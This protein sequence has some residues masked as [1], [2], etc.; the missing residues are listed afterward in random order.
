MAGKVKDAL[1]STARVV[2]SSLNDKEV[3]VRL[4]V[5]LLLY[6][7][8]IAFT[9]AYGLIQNHSRNVTQELLRLPLTSKSFVISVVRFTHSLLPLYITMRVTY[10]IGFTG[11][12][13]L[14]VFFILIYW[15]DLKASDEL[16]MRYLLAYVSCGLIYSIFHVYA[17]HYVYHIPGFY[18]DNTYLTRQ[19]FV[20]PS[21]HNTVAMINLLTIWHHRD[22]IWAKLLI[23][24]NLMIPFATVLLGHHWVYDA[25]AGILLAFIIVKV[26]S[27]HTLK[28]PESIREMGVS[29]IQRVTVVG[30]L[31][32]LSV[33][34]LAIH[35]PK[36]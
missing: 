29:H 34:L 14:T 30:L 2:K 3:L 23:L 11:S 5:L 27:G 7:G 9:V 33:L 4:N 17:P 26:T 12:I 8:W 24:L 18:L 35:T 31:V 13:A 10:Y 32:G 25:V 19:E 1:A 6:L 36:P 28:V 21:L 20:F 22:K 15:R 16:A